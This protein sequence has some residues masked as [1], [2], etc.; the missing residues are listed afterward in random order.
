MREAQEEKHNPVRK[1]NAPAEI[2]LTFNCTIDIKEYAKVREK[3]NE[4]H[5][6]F[7]FLHVL[8]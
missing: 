7:F 8:Y 4:Y 5:R 1:K 3:I 2:L 6:L